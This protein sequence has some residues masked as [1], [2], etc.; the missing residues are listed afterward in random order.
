MKNL[1][2][3]LLSGPNAQHCMTLGG[4]PLPTELEP[5]HC[6]FAGSTGTGKTTLID[7]ILCTT[8]PRGDRVIV[9]DRMVTT[10]PGSL[11]PATPY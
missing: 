9:C 7:E 3:N 10:C 11:N 2:K 6:L 4:V 1:L 8:I 5:L